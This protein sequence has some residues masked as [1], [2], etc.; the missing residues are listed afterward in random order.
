MFFVML[1]VEDMCLRVIP[2]WL[3]TTRTQDLYQALG[4]EHES[5]VYGCTDAATCLVGK[6]KER[7]DKLKHGEP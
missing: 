5:Q 4:L 2:K 3:Q 6:S 7:H 1:S